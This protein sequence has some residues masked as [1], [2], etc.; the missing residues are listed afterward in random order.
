MACSAYIVLFNQ[1]LYLV[2]EYFHHP[3]MEDLIPLAVLLSP[4]PSN[5]LSAVC[6][7]GS[8]WSEHLI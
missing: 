5:H 2:L 7:Y 4:A 6:P 3:Q 8:A 1:H